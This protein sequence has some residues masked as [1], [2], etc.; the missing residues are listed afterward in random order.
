M[1]IFNLSHKRIQSV[2]KVNL[3]RLSE[4][5]A[6]VKEIMYFSKNFVYRAQ[7]VLTQ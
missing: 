2:I 3:F 5:N 1:M 7:H 6:R 4:D